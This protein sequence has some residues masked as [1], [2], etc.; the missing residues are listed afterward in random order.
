LRS[1]APASP[2]PSL[3]GNSAQSKNNC[4]EI[5]PDSRIGIDDLVA[6]P[7]EI[8]TPEIIPFVRDS[9]KDSIVVYDADSTGS[10]IGTDYVAAQ[11]F[12]N[13]M[14]QLRGKNQGIARWLALAVLTGTIAALAFVSFLA[15]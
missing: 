5:P 10:I 11:G 4:Y 6:L 3:S 7:L 8:M 1:F 14:R 13:H 2:P 9:E 12:A 15:R